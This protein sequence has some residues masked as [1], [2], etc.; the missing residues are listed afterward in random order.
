MK[1]GTNHSWVKRIKHCSKEGPSSSPRSDNHIN[2]KI[3]WDHSKIF[4]RTTEPEENIFTGKLSD[5]I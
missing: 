2:A 3:G 5:V 1:L 4:S